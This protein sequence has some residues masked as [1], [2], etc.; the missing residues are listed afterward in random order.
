MGEVYRARDTRLDR[1]VAI[2]ILP[3][4]LS[5]DP[6]RK[7]RFEREA[8]A[9][10]TLNHPNICVL[11]DVG[12][13]DGIEYLVMECIDGDTLAKRLER[14]A[15]PTEQVL[16]IG[17]EIADGLDKAHRSGVVH[18]DLKPGNIMLTKT[19]AKLLDFGLAKPAVS[20]ASAI[21]ITGTA[22]SSPVTEQGMIVGTFQYMSP[23]QV[24][25]KELD[26]RSDIFSLGAV[27][28]EMLTGQRAFEGKSQLS[29]AS[30]ILEKEP[31]PISSMKPMTP[32]SL[33]HIVRR[34]LAKD[35]DERWQSAR[36]LALELKSLSQTDSATERA[37]PG[38]SSHPRN[39]RELLAW[40]LAGLLA[41]ITAFLLFHPRTGEDHSQ[42]T[43]RSFILP[44]PKYEFAGFWT[45]PISPDGR[46]LAF[47]A[48]SS[49]G[50]IQLW[51]RPVDSLTAKP[52]PGTNGALNPFW[53]S[54]SLWIG[55]FSN[56]KLK[57]ISVNGG[58]PLDIC[59]SAYG[60]GGTWGPDGTILF[61]PDI[62]VPV[63]SVPASGGTPVAATQLDK[64]LQEVAHRWPVFLPD[65]KHFV[66]LSR[67]SENAI[68][69]ASLGST[70]R[71]LILKNDSN[72]LYALPGYL[73]FVRNRVLMAQ[74]FD[75][76]RLELAGPAIPIAEDVPVYGAIQLA[77]FSVSQNGI[78][79]VQTQLGKIVQPV[80]VDRFGKTLD[81]LG[82]PA[83]FE[84]LRVSPN[85]EKVAFVVDDPQEG[86]PNIWVYDAQGHQKT[87]LTFGPTATQSPIWSPDGNR[88]VFL[89]NLKGS[90]HLFTIFATGVGQVEPLLP[91]DQYEIPSSW[92]PDGSYLAFMR[93]ILSGKGHWN[94]WILPMSGDKKPYQL[95]D[96]NYDQAN[97]TFSSDGKWLAFQSNETGGYEIYLVP[98]P[99]ATSKL[100]VSTNGGRG[101]RWSPDGKELY[102]RA[103]DGTVMA[104][105]LQNGKAGLQ[106]TATHP[107]FKSRYSFDV[108]H[109]GKRFLTFRD[110]ENQPVA[111]ITLITNW[112]A[113]LKKK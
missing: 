45:A 25:G 24:E 65:G 7:Q 109:D 5:A 13:Q 67:G 111:P 57:K 8:K 90:P 35:P 63:Y 18:R 50:P 12:S 38:S 29:V 113:E 59:E 28:Y 61:V 20:A 52:L 81:L 32:Q 112:T 84:S 87:R 48:A 58:A 3:A 91:S 31:A 85:G 98:F 71:K 23:E 42:Q 72:V 19:G 78:L 46:F 17:T 86:S 89:S 49:D 43:V 68:Y 66:F 56:N 37:A 104:A 73:L 95:L 101:P 106:V 6:A 47:V 107:L 108:S 93:R 9:I 1:T 34:C 80:W 4:Q 40:T 11:Y 76:T 53:S 92:S 33:D 39:S 26:G 96:S 64:S 105:S 100:A 88:I 99:N 62:G 54:D 21:T 15:L 77:L 14:G 22:G 97:A 74:P 94:L 70:E 16:K 69:A 44:P 36:D 51:I 110:V 2:K 55:F 30:A 27:L 102:Y 83:M 82:E 10:S 75:A 79:S 103:A 60:R 41:L